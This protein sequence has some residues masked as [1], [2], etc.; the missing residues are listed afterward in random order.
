[1]GFL[2]YLL[3]P[4]LF[5]NFYFKGTSKEEQI[6]RYI[7]GLFYAF[8]VFYIGN[9]DRSISFVFANIKVIAVFQLIFTAISFASNRKLREGSSTGANVFLLAT[10][11]IF[12]ASFIYTS[13]PYINGGAK[14]LAK[15]ANIKESTEQSPKINT[16]NIIIIPPETAYYQMQNL[17]GSLPNPSLYK[18]GEIS[19]TKTEQGAFYVAPVAIEGGI[20][21][22]I[23]KELPGVVYVSAEK[24]SEA[25]FIDAPQKYG[26]SLVLGHDL[27]RKLRQYKKDAILLNANVELDDNLKPYYVGSYGHYKYGRK[28]I[29]T[30][31][32]LI[33]DIGTGSITDYEKDKA[34]Q[35][36]DQVYTTKVAEKYNTYYGKLKTGFINSIIGQKGV[37]IP[38][39]W[40]SGVQLNGLEIE[41]RQ[42]VPVVGSNNEFYYFTDHTNTSKSSTTMTGFTLMNTRTGEMTYYKTAGFIN[43]DGAMKAIDKLLGANQSN[44]A[45]A[46]PILY[47]LYGIDTWIVPVINKADGSFV[48]IG[49]VT[50]QSK[51]SI[52][53]D[54]KVDLLDSFKKAVAD[55]RVNQGSDVKVNN[56]ASLKELEVEGIILRIN[57]A[58][59]GGQ[60]VF[61]IKLDKNSDK[62]FMINKNV[63][64]DIVLA[65]E[66]DKVKVKYMDMEGQKIIPV[67]SFTIEFK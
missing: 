3:L 62:V 10:I 22:L 47:N 43:G 5:L 15:L 46:Q 29:V 30:D 67:T 17:I 40:Q 31:G 26:D 7:F 63:S 57:Q 34:P 65:R 11:I 6:G 60:S 25:K 19:L 36:V 45:T 35:W 12:V 1:M 9:A 49:I 66:N 38:T 64:G 42:V 37:T 14:N 50:A 44:W 58:V 16:E 48:K 54:S 8:L 13:I 20:K 41:S 2:W 61:Y 4:I 56:N 51:F 21:A 23:N 32:V 33:Y 53:S 18:I 55:G 59:E 52:L 39:Q 24:L 28:G 27:Y